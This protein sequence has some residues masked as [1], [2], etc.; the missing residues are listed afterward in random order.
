MAI[1]TTSAPNRSGELVGALAADFGSAGLVG[2][3]SIRPQEL[4]WPARNLAPA[5]RGIRTTHYSVHSQIGRTI[6]EMSG[7]IAAISNQPMSGAIAARTAAGVA[8]IATFDMIAFIDG[9]R[10]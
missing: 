4:V 6:I 3:D 2:I 8:P 10:A 7:P 9:N 1:N 5:R